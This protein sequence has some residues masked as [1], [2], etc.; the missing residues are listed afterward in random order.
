MRE[1][2]SGKSDLDSS[3]NGS[4]GRVKKVKVKRDILSG[5]G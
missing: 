2:C 1:S 4:S 3:I 5:G